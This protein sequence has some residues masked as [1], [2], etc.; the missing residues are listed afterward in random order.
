[1]IFN[2]TTSILRITP[3]TPTKSIKSITHLQVN[4]MDTTSPPD[5]PQPSK[6][7]AY[8]QPSN[9]ISRNPQEQRGQPNQ[10]SA[11]DSSLMYA[12][13]G[14]G[15]SVRA[16]EY[17]EPPQKPIRRTADSNPSSDEKL[18]Q[19]RQKHEQETSPEGKRGHIDLEYGI[20]QQ[21]GEGDIAHAVEDNHSETATH[22]R[23]QPGVHAGAVGTSS[24]G[25]EQDT[26]AQMD[27]KRAEH[28][29][30]LGLGRQEEVG[31]KSPAY[32]GDVDREDK[33]G[34]G[35]DA[36]RRQVR[37]EKLRTDQEVDAKGAVKDATGHP[38]V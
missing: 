33:V 28:D 24:P 20:E 9:P 7:T 16:H 30:M 35:V 13:S 12:T 3:I 5:I 6:E 10:P 1:M 25:F 29:R 26:A 37:Q 31:A 15:S 34:G 23:V 4:K 8:T 32:Y 17:G 21:P 36:E 19:L 27:R 38:A 18:S 22:Q 14:T 11:P 2:K